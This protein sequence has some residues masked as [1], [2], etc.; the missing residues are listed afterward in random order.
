M[1][2]ATRVAD[3]AA[4]HIGEVRSGLACGCTCP[5]CGAILEAVNS[6]NPFWKRRPHFRHHDSHELDDCAVA[7]LLASSRAAL[8]EVT[9]FALPELVAEGKATSSEG[10]VFTETL[11]E[12]SEV[13]GVTAYEF[14]D[15]TDAVL[16]LADGQQVYVRLIAAGVSRGDLQAKQTVFAEIIIDI[17]DPMLRT[18]DR[19]ALRRHIS[20]NPGSRIWCGNQ[21][22]AELQR[23]A[24]EIARARAGEHRPDV[25]NFVPRPGLSESMSDQTAPPSRSREPI[26]YVWAVTAPSI[27]SAK[28]RQVRAFYQ[29][30][31]YRHYA[32][33]IDY[34]QVL[35]HAQRARA[36]GRDLREELA[37]WQSSYSLYD[38][39][40][41]VL[42]VLV[43]AGLVRPIYGSS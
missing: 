9:D 22:V 8:I 28:V 42:A 32:P 20:L 29:D 17:S 19:D 7:A 11:R 24:D 18:A 36:E 13:Q 27:T 10:K 38:D 37:R 4:I 15:T 23:L 40:K 35:S 6:E 1:V 2:W 3:R 26:G 39:L 12:P 34:D 5:G 31:A 30:G 41:P 21:R 16:T 33:R 14:V 43:A 25:P